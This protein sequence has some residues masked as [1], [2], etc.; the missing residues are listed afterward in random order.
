MTQHICKT[1]A[2]ESDY[3]DSHPEKGVIFGNHCHLTCEFMVILDGYVSVG[4]EDRIYRNLSKGTL[5]MIPPLTYHSSVCATPCRYERMTVRFSEKEI[6][7]E[8]RAALLEKMKNEP[9]NRWEE[10]EYLIGS[11][12]ETIAAQDP[13]R[14]APLIAGIMTQLF[15]YSLESRFGTVGAEKDERLERA[16]AYID[17]N[18]SSKITLDDVAE[19]SYLS[20]STLCHLFQRQMKISVKQYMI[21]K[22]IHYAAGLIQSG[23]PSVRAAR[24]IGYNNYADFYAVFKKTTGFAPSRA[25]SEKK[26]PGGEN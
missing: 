2:F 7:G 12:R 13:K 11:L 15:Y 23:I 19:H 9:V 26:E 3:T 1:P 17:R 8:I 25:K 22:K 10:A 20:V 6:P 24:M 16:I 4:I 5:V 21:Q 14:N 18:M